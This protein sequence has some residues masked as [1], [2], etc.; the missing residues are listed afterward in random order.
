MKQERLYLTKAET[1]VMTALWKLNNAT[2]TSA[3]IMALLPEPKP[4]P[5]TL[6]T[7]L[8]ILTTKGF[9]RTERMGRS[10][11][12]SAIVS[13]DDYATDAVATV[14]DNFFGGSFSSLVSFFAQREEMS[15]AEIDELIDLIKHRGG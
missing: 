10:N 9:V 8:H 4:A 14:K 6:L 15:V 3:E 1:Q 11:R 13:H 2:G 12:F 7:F 5:T